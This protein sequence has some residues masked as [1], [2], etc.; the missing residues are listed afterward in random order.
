MEL[1]YRKI[2]DN[3][4]KSYEFDREKYICLAEFFQKC[5]IKE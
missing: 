5:E 4:N 1:N 3:D 2:P